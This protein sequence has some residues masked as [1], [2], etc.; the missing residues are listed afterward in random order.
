MRY[1]FRS[2]AQALT[3]AQRQ[4]VESMRANGGQTFLADV[5]RGS[6]AHRA[7]SAWWRVCQALERQ[8]VVRRV[9]DRHGLVDAFEL[10]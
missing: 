8:G 2:A 9:R 7:A 4:M 6:N 1:D 5:A 10:V 3:P